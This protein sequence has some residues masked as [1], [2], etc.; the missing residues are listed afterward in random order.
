[1]KAGPVEAEWDQGL[2]EAEAGVVAENIAE[3]AAD[4]PSPTTVVL[5]QLS[6]IT[7][8]NPAVAVVAA[9]QLVEAELDRLAAH[10][11]IERARMPLPMALAR[12]G[13][14]SRSTGAA[15]DGLRRLRNN[16]VHRHDSI[17][18][19]DQALGFVKVT[20]DVLK[21]LAGEHEVRQR[22]GVP[23]SDTGDGRGEVRAGKQS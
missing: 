2:V 23:T 21:I 16:A 14:I 19:Q 12:V 13:L 15:I 20:G 18:T 8:D 3:A 22:F 10:H 9:Y 11:G 7:S 4:A 6:A 1:L 17:I 5:D